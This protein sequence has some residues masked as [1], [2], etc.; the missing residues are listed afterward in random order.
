MPGVGWLRPGLLAGTLKTVPAFL[1][2]CR[3]KYILA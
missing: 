2:S 1:T 3:N